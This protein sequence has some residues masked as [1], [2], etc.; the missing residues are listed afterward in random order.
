MSS[1]LPLFLSNFSLCGD[2]PLPA[3]KSAEHFGGLRC[4]W[5]IFL[6]IH[7]T[8]PAAL[9]HSWCMNSYKKTNSLNI[10][11]WICRFS[12]FFLKSNLKK[13]MENFSLYYTSSLQ[14]P[15]LLPRPSNNYLLSCW[16]KCDNTLILS[17]YKQSFILI[18][19]QSTL[20]SNIGTSL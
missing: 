16:K 7:F 2:L 9:H 5:K 20:K 8:K 18:A 6:M 17:I 13:E 3:E 11:S 15:K 4:M 1:F 19:I 10:F 12:E 14:L